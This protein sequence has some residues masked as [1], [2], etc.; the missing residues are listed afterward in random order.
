M[1]L[2]IGIEELQHLLAQPR[3]PI[4]VDTRGAEAYAAGHL[5]GAYNV[6]AGDLEP[7]STTME[8]LFGF[9][10]D[11][12]HRFRLLGRFEKVHVVVYGDG[13]DSASVHTFFLFH[14]AGQL[15]T[16]YFPDGYAAWARAGGAVTTET[17]TI[18]PS[19]FA[20]RVRREVIARH[21]EVVAALADPAT[22]LVDGRTPE[23][24]ARGTIPGARSL[25]VANL[26]SE[27]GARILPAEA[28]R[29][30]FAAVGLD[31]RS[32]AIFLSERGAR[33]GLLWLAARLAGLRKARSYLGGLREW[34]RSGGAL[35]TR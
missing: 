10:G 31:L 30:R 20:V 32:P 21:D 18:D 33:S 6:S 24:Q 8:G 23:E 12:D 13:L 2:L 15:A 34:R 22:P 27:D 9:N 26:L 5:P 11:L 1:D 35:E 16:R 25:P 29:D 3:Q 7:T 4:I 17:P 19:P 28:L 14:Y